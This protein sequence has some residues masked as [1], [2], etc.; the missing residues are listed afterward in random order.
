M[1]GVMGG[2]SPHGIA[3]CRVQEALQLSN[4]AY[5]RFHDDQTEPFPTLLMP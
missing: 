4:I 1:S 2:D 3:L 5:I